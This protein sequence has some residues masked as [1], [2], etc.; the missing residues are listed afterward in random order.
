MTTIKLKLSE[1]YVRSLRK[2]GISSDDFVAIV[3]FQNGCCPLCL[4][5]LGL[6]MVLDHDHSVVGA[7]LL[8]SKAEENR[9]HV[10]GVL[11]DFCNRNLGWL[12]AHPVLISE[13]VRSYLEKPPAQEV[14]SVRKLILPA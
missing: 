1:S 5:D 13:N 8:R 4:E 14:L 3:R 12:E 6:D 10:R 11:H 7:K 9:R 2:Y